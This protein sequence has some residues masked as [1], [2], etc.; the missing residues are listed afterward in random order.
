MS[1]I[2]QKILILPNKYQIGP[3]RAIILPCLFSC[4]AH[5]TYCL[6]DTWC[7][8]WDMLPREPHPSVVWEAVATTEAASFAAPHHGKHIN[9]HSTRTNSYSAQEGIANREYIYMYIY[10]YISMDK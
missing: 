6:L 9:S 1:Y 3:Y 7:A 8:A 2:K 10:I 4:G 5:W